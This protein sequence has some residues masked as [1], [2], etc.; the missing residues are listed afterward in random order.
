M[1]RR[2]NK[3]LNVVTDNE[4][5]TEGM[6]DK[7]IAQLNEEDTPMEDLDERIRQHKKRFRIKVTISAA[8]IILVTVGSYLLIHLQTYTSART[9]AVYQSD[10]AGNNNYEQ[11]AGGVLKYSRD[12]AALLD[13]KGEERW[14]QPYQIKNPMID[15]YGESAAIADKGGNAIVVFDKNGLKGEIQTTLPIEKIAVS[16]QGIVSAVLKN[17]SSPKIICYDAAGNL[18]AEVKTSLAGTG[19]PMDISIS[20]DGKLLL[21]SYMSV[22]N[23]LVTSN[24]TYYN[25]GDESGEED[26]YQAVSHSYEDMVAPSTFF[27]N[28]N[29]SVVAGDDRVLIYKGK[30]KPEL[31][32]T[33]TLKKEIKSVFY[34][35]RYIG[36]VLKN[37]GKAGYELCLYNTNGKKVMSEDF[38][39][40]YTNVKIDGSQVIMYDGKKC[41]VFTRTGI[42]KF[43]GE[44][45]NSIMEMY[46]VF[47]VNK[48]VVM[49]ANGMEVIRFVK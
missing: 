6:I 23:G 22:Q 32:S 10:S 31:T 14:N 45:G 49:N 1:K 17:E 7:L 40:D 28:D 21:V 4:E 34:N 39:G 8:L 15:V 18:L 20:E 35:S 5:L 46:P 24:I 16:S 47:G 9:I 41:S 38:T 12:G 11:F 48:Y 13:G 19:Y 27:M 25:F 2:K 26:N 33:A 36:L 29:V 44:L 42:R 37:E 30:T 43:N 3:D